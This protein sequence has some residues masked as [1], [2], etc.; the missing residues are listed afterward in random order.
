MSPS[1]HRT[2]IVLQPYTADLAANHLMVGGLLLVRFRVLFA[3][4]RLA[5]YAVKVKIQSSYQLASPNDPSFT[6]AVPNINRPA[7]MTDAQRPPNEGHVGDTPQPSRSQ[8]RPPRELPLRILESGEQWT[9]THLGRVPGDNFV[10]PTTGPYTE[11]P[12]RASHNIILEVVYRI[13]GDD[14]DELQR[15]RSRT[16]ANEEEGKR[17]LSITKPIELSSCCCFVD[18]LTLPAYSEKDPFPREELEYVPP[19]ACAIGTKT[20]ADSPHGNGLRD[21]AGFQWQNDTSRGAVKVQPYSDSRDASRAPSRTPSRPSSRAPSPTNEN[22]RG[23]PGVSIYPTTSSNASS[24]RS[25]FQWTGV[26]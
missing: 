19:C 7:I 23:R 18:S 2:D 20:L 10:R 5:V 3:P 14:E 17:M 22:D 25:S 13:L 15:A 4:C 9:L 21:D 6:M 26:Q 8:S 16:R 24:S 12:I 1:T 11:T